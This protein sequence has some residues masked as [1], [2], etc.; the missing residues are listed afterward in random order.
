VASCVVFTEGGPDNSQY[1][2]FNIKGVEGGD[3]YGA[4]EQAITRR[5][6]RLLKEEQALPDILFIDGGKGQLNVGQ[7]VMLSLNISEITLIGVAKGE[8]R[9]AGLETLFI[10]GQPDPII[11]PADSPALLLIQQIRDEAHRFAITGQRKQLQKARTE[12]SLQS[13]PGLGPK[14][15][16]ALLKH[17]GGKRGVKAASTADLAKVTGISPKLASKISDYYQSN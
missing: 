1:R 10:S 11:L 15:R 12:S 9:K 16:Q 14:R 13:I 17:F 8:G 5:Y 2:R 7:Q 4:L 3:D 6:T